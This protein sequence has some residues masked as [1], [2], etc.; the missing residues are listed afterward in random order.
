MTFVTVKVDEIYFQEM[1][2]RDFMT[3]PMPEN[4]RISRN[5]AFIYLIM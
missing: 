2:D 4:I 1:I 5:R 3:K